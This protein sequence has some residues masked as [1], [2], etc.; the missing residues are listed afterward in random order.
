MVNYDY[1]TWKYIIKIIIGQSWSVAETV[2]V[3]W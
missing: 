3:F 2:Y 1:E